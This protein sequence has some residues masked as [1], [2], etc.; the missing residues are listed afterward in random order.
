ML[1]I[2]VIP[3]KRLVLALVGIVGDDRQLGKV[4]IIA[5]H[6]AQTLNLEELGNVINYLEEREQ[7]WLSTSK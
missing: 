5:R 6:L 7:P 4:W 3:S 1:Y 2:P